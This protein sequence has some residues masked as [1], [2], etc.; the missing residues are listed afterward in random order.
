MRFRVVHGDQK[1][2]KVAFHLYVPFG[3]NGSVVR[4]YLIERL[5]KVV[6]LELVPY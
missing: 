5:M 1:G 2:P 3:M 6:E 4:Y